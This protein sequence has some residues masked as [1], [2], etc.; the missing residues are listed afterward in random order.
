MPRPPRCL[1]LNRITQQ[2][3]EQHLA[4][5]C[6]RILPA[7]RINIMRTRIF[8][9]GAKPRCTARRWRIVM[10]H[11]M[12]RAAAHALALT[13]SWRLAAALGVLRAT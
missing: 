1:A 12:T 10:A 8:L 5:L 3:R 2:A 9:S 11:K 7:A 6:W 4:H 13:R